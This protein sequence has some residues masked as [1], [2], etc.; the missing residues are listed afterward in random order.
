M[1]TI[2]AHLSLAAI[3]LAAF[4]MEAA[5]GF[6]C[7]VLAVTLGVHLLPLGQL[8]PLLIVLNLVVSAFIAGRHRRLI[9]WRVLLTRVLPLMLAGL[10]G[11]L[12]LYAVAPEQWLKLG[13][14]VFVV[15]ISTLELLRLRG[16]VAGSPPL[17]GWAA[18]AALLG[19]GLLHGLYATGGPLAVYYAGRQLPDKGAFR[20][21]MS[22]LWLVLNG[23]ML[24]TFVAR[25]AAEAGTL[26]L[27]ATMLPSLAAG[28]VGGEWLHGR[29]PELTFR[30]LVFA[31]L[32]LGGA[33]LVLASLR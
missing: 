2:P 18:V 33:V 26:K 25:G 16:A 32:L 17:P 19:A 27:A 12:L 22:L 5:M 21:T 11:G 13:F 15:A 4:G 10:P 8:L 23:V 31:L 9:G 24:A 20:A 29:L 6:G 7:N 30:R 3:V 28:I 14:G 1:L